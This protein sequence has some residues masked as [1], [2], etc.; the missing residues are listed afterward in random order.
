MIRATITIVDRLPELHRQVEALARRAAAAG[1]AAAAETAQATSS[2]D[3]ELAVIPPGPD[4]DGVAAG[5]RS[6]K[7][8]RADGARI[9]R[10]F[11]EGTLGNRRKP[12]KR[13]G[14]SSWT[15]NRRGSSYT[16]HRGDVSGKGIQPERFF[17][18]AR[19]AGRKAMAEVIGR[20]L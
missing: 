14:R 15:V 17:L 9:G 19:L 7:K 20:G 18:K 13:P 4:P 6:E 10:F 16:A 5:I 12:P 11:D 3:L 2:I 8:G 1:A